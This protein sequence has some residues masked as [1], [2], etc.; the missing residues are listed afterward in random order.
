MP[1]RALLLLLVC[2]A[3]LPAA[4]SFT[5]DSWGFS[6][7]PPTPAPTTAPGIV[8][9]A[10]FCIPGSDGF[11][12]NVNVQYQPFAGDLDAYD[13]TTKAQFEQLRLQIIAMRAD[14]AWHVYEYAGKLQLNRSLHCYAKAAKRP[15]GILLVTAT[16]L[17]TQWAAVKD[18]LMRSVESVALRP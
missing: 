8:T 17:D 11:N 3:L 14:G 18:S 12:P 1:F 5:S 6:I 13:A 7:Q 15:G 9:L 10:A 2:T 16:A 4:D